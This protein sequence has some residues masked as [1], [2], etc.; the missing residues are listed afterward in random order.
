MTRLRGALWR[1]A[2]LL[3]L[4]IIVVFRIDPLKGWEEPR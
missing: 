3:A 2:A 1:V 4:A